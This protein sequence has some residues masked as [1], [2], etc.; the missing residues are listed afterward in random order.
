MRV[1]LLCGGLKVQYNNLG[2]ISYVLFSL[3][4]ACLFAYL[5]VS[6]TTEAPIRS[7]ARQNARA[8]YHLVHTGVMGADSVETPT[9]KPQL[10][11]EP[12]PILVIAALLLVH[13]DFKKHYTIAELTSGPLAKTAKEVNAFWRF[14][15]T[16]FIFLLC[17]ELF[18]HR[19]LAAGLALVCLA[20]SEVLF[21]AN[22]KNVDG[23]F[24]E[25][26]A[27][28]LILMASWSAVRFV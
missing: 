8:A 5:T 9:P 22:P 3:S 1:S 4:V 16:L 7:D 13:P 28:A 18:S 11:R 19:L 12:V 10:H 21:F 27:A 25:I 14:L 15:A 24:T 2:R 6:Y 26:P 17:K 23:L 20:S